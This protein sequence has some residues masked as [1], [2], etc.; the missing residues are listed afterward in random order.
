M[1]ALRRFNPEFI[2]FRSWPRFDIP[3][4]ILSGGK[5]VL[6]LEFRA[7]R[8][9]IAVRPEFMLGRLRLSKGLEVVITFEVS[10]VRLVFKSDNGSPIFRPTPKVGVAGGRPIPV[11]EELMGL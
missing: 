2:P 7:F 3:L 4:V 9:F 10:D 5:L 11:P 8:G 1:R 6:R